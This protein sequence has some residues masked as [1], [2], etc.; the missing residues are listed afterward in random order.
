M[1]DLK[2]YYWVCALALIFAILWGFN[3]IFSVK[4]ENLQNQQTTSAQIKAE[5][6]TETQIVYVPKETIVYVDPSTG[7]RITT[8]EKT[9]I[10]A[11][12]GK[13]S[14][15]IK[16]NGKET[17]VQKEDNERFVFDKNKI[18]LDQQS[19]IMINA[20]I[21]PVVINKT[22]HWGIGVGYGIDNKMGAIL[23]FPI[24]K[25]NNV[26]GWVYGDEQNKCGGIMIRF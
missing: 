26:D 20:Q 10:E 12:I 17:E 4:S 15:N 9:D 18:V 11:N 1:D 14:V 3:F 22:K 21:D 7:K 8:K 25:K 6:K 23:T 24:N 19:N 16:I 13:P 5:T 2:K